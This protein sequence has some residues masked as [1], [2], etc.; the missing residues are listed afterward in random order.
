MTAH[1]F[2]LYESQLSSAGPRYEKRES[3]PLR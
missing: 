1:Q 3:F 2:F